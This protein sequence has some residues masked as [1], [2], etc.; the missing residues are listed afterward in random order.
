MKIYLA[1]LA[2]CFSSIALAEFKTPDAECMSLL[3]QSRLPSVIAYK[4]GAGEE[5]LISK[6]GEPVVITKLGTFYPNR[7]DCEPNNDRGFDRFVANGILEAKKEIHESAK[8]KEIIT[9]C[10]KAKSETIKEAALAKSKSGPNNR[11]DVK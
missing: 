1:F 5:S 9:E 2:L 3:F 8:L 4:W 11:P 6:E 7:P 10:A